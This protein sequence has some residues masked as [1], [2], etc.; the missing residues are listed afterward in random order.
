[1]VL[2]AKQKKHVERHVLRYGTKCSWCGAAEWKVMQSL[3]SVRVL[4]GST[5]PRVLGVQCGSCAHL[6]FFDAA[7]ILLPIT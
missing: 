7:G 4:R 3:M 5:G 1:M 2:T 6:V